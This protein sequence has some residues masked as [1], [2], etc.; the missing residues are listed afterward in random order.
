MVA[1][2]DRM[3]RPAVAWS[4]VLLAGLALWAWLLAGQRL[5]S[6]PAPASPAAALE[7][8]LLAWP[9]A[10]VAAVEVAQGSARVRIERSGEAWR[11]T[12]RATGATSS[13]QDLAARLAMFS[14]ARIERSF[15]VAADALAEYGV[16]ARALTVRIF[17]AASGAPARELRFGARTPDGFGQ[18][19]WLRE[20]ARMV[21]VPAYHAAN[22]AALLPASD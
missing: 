2:A 13:A 21:T 3:S 1:A 12:D 17:L 18:Y 15:P 14:A 20:S 4:C 16:G 9:L 19:A 22:L 11:M 5:A 6:S 8:R 10:E 7:E